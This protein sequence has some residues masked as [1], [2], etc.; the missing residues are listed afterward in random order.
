MK[1]IVKNI[2][3]WLLLLYCIL[4]FVWGIYD[5]GFK[6]KT[7]DRIDKIEN[8]V[9]YNSEMIIGHDTI[10]KQILLQMGHLNREFDT[11]KITLKRVK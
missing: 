8:V 4:F 2:L 6:S 3:L 11:I 7:T 1:K 9:K 10:F 5:F